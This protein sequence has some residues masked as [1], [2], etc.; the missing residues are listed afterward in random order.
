VT[1]ELEADVCWMIDRPLTAGSRYVI[2]HTT[3]SAKAVVGEI[4]H[5]LD[6]NTLQEEAGVGELGLNGIGR[7]RL[8]V[9]A[10]LAVDAYAQ[11]RITGSFILI[12]EGTNATA[13]A[14]LIRG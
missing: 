3:R 8:R 4:V 11:N 13:G 14:G 5:R 10:P 7:V 9:S 6:V 1:Q 2:K 12:D